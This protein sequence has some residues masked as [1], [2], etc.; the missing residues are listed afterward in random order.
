VC[1]VWLQ[2]IRTI[3]VM[4]LMLHCHMQPLLVGQEQVLLVTSFKEETETDLFGEQA[5]LCGGLAQLI[6]YG[7]KR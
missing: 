7:L 6:K 1:L 5:V 3:Q 2:S 4:R